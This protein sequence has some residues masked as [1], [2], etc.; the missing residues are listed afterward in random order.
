MK[1]KRMPTPEADRWIALATVILV[2]CQEDKVGIKVSAV[3]QDQLSSLA[4]GKRQKE[5]RFPSWKKSLPGEYRESIKRATEGAIQTMDA[6]A[7]SH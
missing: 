1:L 6:T 7:C 3:E 2:A 4:L 5:T